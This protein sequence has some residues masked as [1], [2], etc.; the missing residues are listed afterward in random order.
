MM[1][2]LKSL[3]K[4]LGLTQAELAKRAAL[5]RTTVTKI[6]S[7]TYNPTVNT[8]MLLA[9]AMNKKLVFKLV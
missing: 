2:E 6:E 1:M 7:G 8:L 3:R 9:A 5:P 4:K